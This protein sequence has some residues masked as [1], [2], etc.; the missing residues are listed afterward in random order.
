MI[1][2]AVKKL[3]SEH[4]ISPQLFENLTAHFGDEQLA[5]AFVDA[6]I[7]FVN[8]CGGDYSSALKILANAYAVVADLRADERRKAYVNN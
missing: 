8:Q 5:A 3:G 6:Q 1:L 4:S 7:E 2:L